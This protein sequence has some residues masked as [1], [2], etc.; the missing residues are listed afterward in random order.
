VRAFDRWRPLAARL[1][2]V[3][4]N[5]WEA[6][7]FC[8]WAGRRLPTEWE[9]ELAA[10]RTADGERGRY[11]WGREPPAPARANLDGARGGPVAVDA[12]A[13]GD[14]PAG[15]RQLVGNVWEW[16][17]TVFE[18]LP[19][20]RPGPYAE[21]SRPWFGTHRV[22]R[23]GC[24]ATRARLVSSAYRNFFTPDRRDVMAGFRTAAV[25]P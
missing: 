18:P 20:F 6:G 14:S 3:H 12:L 21:Y 25:E 9:W 17:S 1:P 13:G 22:L 4:V 10:S 11:P 8:R 23:G 24:W 19:G 16:T 2:V 5:A 7:A 15:C